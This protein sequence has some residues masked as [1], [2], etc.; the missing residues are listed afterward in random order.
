MTDTPSAKIDVRV[1]YV[2]L[3]GTES[4]NRFLDYSWH[5]SRGGTVG[6][7]YDLFKQV[8]D[9]LAQ[10]PWRLRLVR[11]RDWF[12]LYAR[13]GGLYWISYLWHYITGR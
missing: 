11:R 6:F 9:L 2:F 7:S 12:A 5:G 8:P 10:L 4:P 1:Q 3:S 13:V